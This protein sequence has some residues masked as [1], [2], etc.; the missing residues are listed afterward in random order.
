MFNETSLCRILRSYF[1]YYKP[2]PI[3]RWPTIRPSSDPFSRWKWGESRRYHW[4]V[5][6]TTATN[7]AP[8][9]QTSSFINSSY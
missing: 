7:D 9:E 6:F 5:D 3:S 1:E 8:P 4:S 2:E